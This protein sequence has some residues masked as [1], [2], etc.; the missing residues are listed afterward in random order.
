MQGSVAVDTLA[1]LEKFFLYGTMVYLLGKAVGSRLIA[2]L[3]AAT[4]LFATSWAEVYLPGRSAEST[5]GLLALIIAVIFAL[6]PAEREF[7]GVTE[8][9]SRPLTTRERQLRDWQQAQARALGV[10]LE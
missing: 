9:K 4:V 5:D 7:G 1:F 6:L 2:A 10:K 8:P 3:F